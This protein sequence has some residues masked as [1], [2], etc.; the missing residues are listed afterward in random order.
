MTSYPKTVKLFVPWTK[1]MVAGATVSKP[2]YPG[3]KSFKKRHKT[4]KRR[5]R[6]KRKNATK[7][8]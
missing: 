3:T 4:S 8:T 6:R 7:E 2:S 5:R 1:A